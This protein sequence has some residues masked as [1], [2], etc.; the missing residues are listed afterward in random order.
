MLT[1]FCVSCNFYYREAELLKDKRCPECKVV[2]K[3]RVMLGGRVI[4]DA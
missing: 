3:P 1:Y 2:A 4:G